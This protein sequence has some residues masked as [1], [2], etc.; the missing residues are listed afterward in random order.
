MI[1]SNRN[2]LFSRDCVEADYSAIPA[3]TG[4]GQHYQHVTRG[5]EPGVEGTSPQPP[6]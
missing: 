5:A 3:E 1:C 2:G 6:A 4:R